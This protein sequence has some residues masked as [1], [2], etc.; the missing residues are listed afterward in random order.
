MERAGWTKPV[1][2]TDGRYVHQRK[3][4]KEQQWF[5]HVGLIADRELIRFYVEFPGKNFT[6]VLGQVSAP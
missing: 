6:I 4:E 5:I 2:L 3:H 1:I